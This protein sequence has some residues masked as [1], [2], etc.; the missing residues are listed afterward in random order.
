[1]VMLKY[2]GQRMTSETVTAMKNG[3]HGATCLIF[4][5]LLLPPLPQHV[6]L[7]FQT[8]SAIWERTSE[9]IKEPKCYPEI[10][11]PGKN[12]YKVINQ[13]NLDNRYFCKS[14]TDI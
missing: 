2:S 6:T 13:F 1:M 14:F 4:L 9:L 5:P 12:I 11:Y 3:S 8:R 7:K 10:F